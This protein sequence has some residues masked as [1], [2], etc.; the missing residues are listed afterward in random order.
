MYGCTLGLMGPGW[1]DE[2]VKKIAQNVAQPIF[3]KITSE[4]Y[5]FE[6]ASEKCGLLWKSQSR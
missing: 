3:V 1:P 2:F 5:P 4:P 6:M